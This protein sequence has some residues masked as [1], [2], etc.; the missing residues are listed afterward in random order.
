MAHLAVPSD[1]SYDDAIVARP[2][3]LR[4]I[5]LSTRPA[6]NGKYEEW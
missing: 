5:L 3:V 4:W 2:E 1:G 6:E